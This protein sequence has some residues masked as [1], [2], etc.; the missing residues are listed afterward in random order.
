MYLV[1]TPIGNLGDIGLRALQVMAHADRVFAED[2]RVSRRLL[3]RFG[4]SRPLESLHQQNEAARADD[5]IR[6]MGAEQ[7]A[8]ALLSDAGTPLVSDPGYMLVQAC[9]ASSLPV[10]SVPGASA[11]LAALQVSALPADR[12]GFEGFLPA[13]QGAR[14]ARLRALRH[15]DRTLVLFEAPHRVRETLKDML[16]VLGPEREVCVVR[17]LT[18]LHETHYR[19][20]LGDVAAAIAADANAERGEIAIVVGPAEASEPDARA[21]VELLRALQRRM[22]RKDAV[23]VACEAT[24]R[25]RNELYAL[26]LTLPETGAA[27]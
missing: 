22:S 5:L 3:D 2:T 25:P 10:R 1:A 17:E 9:V 14:V 27:S 24:G 26:A 20:V 7:R 6:W 18:K 12:F 4:I 13:R 23:E 11:V 8:V 19:G 15:F 21:A 16:D